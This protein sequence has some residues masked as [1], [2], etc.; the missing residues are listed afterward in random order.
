MPFFAFLAVSDSTALV[1]ER[2]VMAFVGWSSTRLL[3]WSKRSAYSSLRGNLGIWGDWYS[4]AKPARWSH[5][6]CTRWRIDW[7]WV[8]PR[9]HTASRGQEDSLPVVAELKR[10]QR[11]LA[12]RL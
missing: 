10:F 12:G 4:V 1:Y 11:A 9:S 7:W 5:P 8:W 3:F 2:A 6:L